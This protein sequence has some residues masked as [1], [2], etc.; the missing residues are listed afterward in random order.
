[1]DFCG[2]SVYIPDVPCNAS[3]LSHFRKRI[4]VEGFNLIFKKSV[5][6]HA[7]AAQTSI[8]LIDTIVQEKNIAIATRC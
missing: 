4:G 1:M 6:T 5:E 3:E 8:V 2:Y 7:K